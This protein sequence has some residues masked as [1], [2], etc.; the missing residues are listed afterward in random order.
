[1]HSVGMSVRFPMWM[2]CIL[3]CLIKFQMVLVDTPRVFAVL[4]MFS[5]MGVLVWFCVVGVLVWFGIMGVLNVFWVE[6][7]GLVGVILLWFCY[8]LGWVLR[9]QN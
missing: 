2:V 3:F 8:D 5:A 7:C 9:F 1:M 4:F 6:F